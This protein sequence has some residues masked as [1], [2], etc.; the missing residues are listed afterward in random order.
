M[1][2]TTWATINPDMINTAVSEQPTRV[3]S[4]CG[5]NNL[6]YTGSYY[7]RDEFWLCPDCLNKLRNLIAKETQYDLS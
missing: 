7:V 5:V 2:L 1:A 3:C 4:V 6:G